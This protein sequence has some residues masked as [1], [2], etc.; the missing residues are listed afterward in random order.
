MKKVNKVDELNKCEDRYE[1]QLGIYNFWEIISK[2]IIIKN[3]DLSVFK[4]KGSGIPQGTRWFWEVEDIKYGKKVYITIKYNFNEYKCYIE[5][6]K[7]NRTRLK[8]RS[9][10]EGVLHRR[11][12][13][14][15]KYFNKLDNNY[16]ESIMRFN[17]INKFLYELE[18]IDL[19]NIDKN[20]YNEEI[21]Y[22][23]DDYKEYNFIKEGSSFYSYSKKYERDPK[24]RLRAIKIHGTKCIACGF[25]FEQAYGVRGRGFIEIHHV[26]PLYTLE[27]EMVINPK[28]DLVPLC[29]NCH[30]M[31]H[32]ER[33]NILTINEL[34]NILNIKYI[35]CVSKI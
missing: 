10:F 6:D 28:T 14:Y 21:E 27:G 12:H 2:D 26:N 17:K 31:V 24:N 3:T 19:N 32:R 13:N 8:W 23:E 4:N 1:N 5:I 7:V 33:E 18:F 22:D 11:F 34:K 30:R 25:D 35:N 20:F 9:D 16:I 29:S 15:E